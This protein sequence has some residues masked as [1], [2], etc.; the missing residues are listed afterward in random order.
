M[1]SIDLDPR[2]RAMDKQA[3]D[4]LVERSRQEPLFA[5]KYPSCVGKIRQVLTR[6]IEDDVLTDAQAKNLEW[7]TGA[8][9]VPR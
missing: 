2:I 7:V 4:A 6:L 9:F 8:V 3:F 1:P 5:I